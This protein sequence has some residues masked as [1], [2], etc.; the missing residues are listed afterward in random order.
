[1]SN[2]AIANFVDHDSGPDTDPNSIFWADAPRIV[3]E[4]DFYGKPVAGHRTEIL[5]QWSAGS[6]YILFVCPY[7]Q[8]NLKPEPN[9]DAETYELWNWDVAEVFFGDDFKNH[10]PLQRV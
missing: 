1:M 2:E 5:L 8:L 9:L 10:S 3:A 6:L 7:R 4:G